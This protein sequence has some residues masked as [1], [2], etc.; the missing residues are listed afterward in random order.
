MNNENKSKYPKIT[1]NLQGSFKTFFDPVVMGI[2]NATP[3]SFF[4]K[5]RHQ[6]VSSA[7]KHTENILEEGAEIIDIGGY[8]SRPGAP[9]V[10]EKEETDRLLPVLKEIRKHFPEVVISVDTFRSAVARQALEEGANIINDISA[11]EDDPAMI[12]LIAEKKPPYIM[13]HKKGTP[14][15]M[16]N[17]PHYDDVNLE[18]I[19][20]FA[21]KI[22]D[23]HEKG[24]SDLIID[25]GFGFGKTTEHNYEILKNLNL[26]KTFSTPVLAGVSRKSMINKVL[27]TKPEE[28]LHGTTV[29]NTLAL[30]N[31][32]DILRVHDVKAAKHAISLTEYYKDID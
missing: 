11:G 8:S 32:A 17:D 20:Y 6:E 30:M 18:I 7:L 27:G 9:E 2:L 31:G 4:D 29:L 23:L 22:N 12:D 14:Q 15:N 5:S 10:S 13:M 28:S 19:N 1:F 16:Q 24:C 21:K 3:D 26:Y 25:P